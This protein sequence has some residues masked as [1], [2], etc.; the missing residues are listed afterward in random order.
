MPELLAYL[1]FSLESELLE[2]KNANLFIFIS[3]SL[4]ISKVLQ[5]REKVLLNK[6]YSVSISLVPPFPF[7]L[8]FFLYSLFKPETL[9]ETPVC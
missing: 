1:S 5:E 3:P 7:S 8:P 9:M 6:L 4:S 2:N